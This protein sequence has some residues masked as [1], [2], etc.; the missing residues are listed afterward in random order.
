MST[1]KTAS[2][3]STPPRWI[4]EHA[5]PQGQA[6]TVQLGPLTLCLA[7]LEQ[8]WCIM[9]QAGDDALDDRA[10]YCDLG[11]V[12]EPPADAEVHRFATQA[13]GEKIRLRPVLADRSVVARPKTPVT[14]PAEDEVTLFVSTPIWVSIELID[15]DRWLAEVPTSRPS[16][17]WMGPNTRSGSAA[18]ASRTAARLLLENVPLRAHRAV[19]RVRVKN[20]ASEALQLERLSVPAPAL[21]LFLDEAGHL[22]TQPVIATLPMGYSG[23]PEVDL[24]EKPLDG[25]AFRLLSEARESADSSRVIKRVLEVLLG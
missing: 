4:G 20:L 14:V 6:L 22:W 7:H 9:A 11:P 1:Q 2:G 17:T 25:S 19:T 24:G 15:P 23:Q 18:Y 12:E 3:E 21:K 13:T 16:D 5:V 8:Q 10:S